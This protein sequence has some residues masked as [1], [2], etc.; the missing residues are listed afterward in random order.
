MQPSLTTAIDIKHKTFN[1]CIQVEANKIKIYIIEVG[2]RTKCTISTSLFWT[3][4]RH[5]VIQYVLNQ[6][7]F[8]KKGQLI[9][10][11]TAS[12]SF[13]G[14]TAMLHALFGRSS[15]SKKNKKSRHKV[16]LKERTENKN[17]LCVL[18]CVYLNAM[19]YPSGHYCC[20]S[21]IYDHTQQN[22]IILN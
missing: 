20:F 3:K 22:W 5:T 15:R 4:T 21:C 18:V 8:Y 13:W 16:K 6:W 1:T 19:F 17:D 7:T 10:L 12:F 14:M 11:R 9:P 2:V